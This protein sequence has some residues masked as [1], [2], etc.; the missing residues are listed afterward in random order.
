MTYDEK[1]YDLAA[2]FLQDEPGLFTERNNVAL[3]AAIQ[4]RIEDWLTNAR[5]NYDGGQP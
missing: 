1:C 3:A 5:D 4:E 2:E